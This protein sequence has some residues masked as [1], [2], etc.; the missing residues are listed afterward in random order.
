[1]KKLKFSAEQINNA[2][3]Q[4]FEDEIWDI[5]DPK[6]GFGEDEVRSLIAMMAIQYMKSGRAFITFHDY[7][8]K[9][10]KKFISCSDDTHTA[11]SKTLWKVYDST[12]D[13]YALTYNLISMVNEA[14]YAC[15]NY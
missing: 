15:K 1:M 4:H 5:T 2:I 13:E 7:A 3:T 14:W 12:E 6:D 9:G 11:V 8:F 10:E